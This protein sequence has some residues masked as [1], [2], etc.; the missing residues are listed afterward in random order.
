[1]ASPVDFT[2]QFFV[3]M[4]T[5]FM[6]W[7]MSHSL[8]SGWV[9]KHRQ[10]ATDYGIDT[11]WCG[12]ARE[13]H[14]LT[15]DKDQAP[16]D[17]SLTF[18]DSHGFDCLAWST[19]DCQVREHFCHELWC[20]G[21]DELKEIRDQCCSC[22]TNTPK[23]LLLPLIMHHK[24]TRSLTGNR[25]SK[26]VDFHNFEVSG[27]RLAQLYLDEFPEWAF[28]ASRFR[29]FFKGAWSPT[30]CKGLDFLNFNGLLPAQKAALDQNAQ[31][32]GVLPAKD[33]ERDWSCAA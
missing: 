22:R 19:R 33:L 1:M 3:M 18:T 16:C 23:C 7:F 26:S 12:A 21:V 5:G 25:N 11:V 8:D 29:G 6:M 4:D 32:A 13:Y 28:W 10:M 31:N 14:E 27:A 2:E 15:V 20:Y 9:G 17:D 24:D 30:K